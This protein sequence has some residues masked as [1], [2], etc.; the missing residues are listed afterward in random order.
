MASVY[1]RSRQDA[2]AQAAKAFLQF[3][4]EPLSIVSLDTDS[5]II[6]AQLCNIL[7]CPLQLYLS[8]S[9]EVPGKLGIGS[10]NQGGGFSYSS[11]LSEGESDY[12]YQ[13]YHGYIEEAQRS[14]FSELNRELGDK[15]VIRNDLLKGRNIIAVADCLTDK[16]NLDSLLAYLK[17][18]VY[19]KL[20][21]CAPLV[22][23]NLIPHLT[24]V[25]DF[26]YYA[27][28][29]DFFY[30]KDHYFEDNSV[31]SRSVGIDTVSNF[32]RIWPTATV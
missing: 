13:E 10:V 20:Y 12:L 31:Y 21:I 8:E 24:Q 25:S 23:N 5:L 26:V 28:A 14:T 19:K 3:K 6:G 29:L 18:V 9:I 7:T 4:N 1:F 11:D 16:V 15:T 30:G 27:G 17:P 2:G 22:M 32:L